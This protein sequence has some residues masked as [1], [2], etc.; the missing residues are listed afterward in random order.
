MFFKKIN[1][2]LEEEGYSYVRVDLAGLIRDY[3]NKRTKVEL[4]RIKTPFLIVQAVKSDVLAANNAKY[5]YDKL[6]SEKKEVYYVPLENH[7]FNLLDDA[8]KVIMLEKI[9]HF[10]NEI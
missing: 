3:V 6:M 8:N 1:I 10:I 2:E 5:I 4:M 7:D 9:F